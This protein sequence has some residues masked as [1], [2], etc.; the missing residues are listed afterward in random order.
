[1]GCG[2]RPD[3]LCLLREGVTRIG[4]GIA[5]ADS[6]VANVGRASNSLDYLPVFVEKLKLNADLISRF[7][8]GFI[9]PLWWSPLSGRQD[10][11]LLVL[12]LQ[13][14]AGDSGYWDAVSAWR[15]RLRL[16]LVDSPDGLSVLFVGYATLSNTA[17]PHAVAI[18]LAGDRDA[19]GGVEVNAAGAT[20]HNGS[21]G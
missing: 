12:D 16:A 15:R 5:V 2:L 14:E 20:A 11:H 10:A 9:A 6:V 8:I 3:K 17:A 7:L 19:L 18:V 1:L 4:Y 21:H 13:L